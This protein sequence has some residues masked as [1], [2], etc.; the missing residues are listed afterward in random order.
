ML[1][2]KRG[3]SPSSRSMACCGIIDHVGRLES[4]FQSDSRIAPKNHKKFPG[5]RQLRRMPFRLA[6]VTPAHGTNLSARWL[7][8]T[9]SSRASHSLIK[10]AT[11]AEITGVPVAE[12]QL[13]FSRL[14]WHNIE[15]LEYLAPAARRPV[16]EPVASRRRPVALTGSMISMKSWRCSGRLDT[17][18][19]PQTLAFVRI[20]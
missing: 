5:L 8:R 11:R 20:P 12:I 15:L 3:M 10:R 14:H 2:S 19:T 13:A 4:S 9:C 6:A 16:P 7:L 17:A 18:G 1:S